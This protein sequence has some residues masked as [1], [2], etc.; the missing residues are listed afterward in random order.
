MGLSMISVQRDGVSYNSPLYLTGQL[1]VSS[2][3]SGHCSWHSP[4]RSMCLVPPGSSPVK[5]TWSVVEGAR[6]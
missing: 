4:G 1:T 3:N 2:S 6:T 5:I